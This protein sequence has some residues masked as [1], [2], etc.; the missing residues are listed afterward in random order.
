[1]HSRAGYSSELNLHTESRLSAISQPFHPCNGRKGNMKVASLPQARG[2]KLEVSLPKAKSKDH[3]FIE[4]RFSR[5]LLRP[6]RMLSQLVDH[7]AVGFVRGT[8]PTP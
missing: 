3:S 7:T 8:R 5:F 1:M 2:R 6:Y 4:H